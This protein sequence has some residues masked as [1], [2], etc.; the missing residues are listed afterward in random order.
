MRTRL[1]VRHVD[2]DWEAV[3]R[4]HGARFARCAVR[5]ANTLV[6]APRRRPHSYS[7]AL[8]RLAPCQVGAALVGSEYLVEVEAEAQI[9]P[10]E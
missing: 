5:P 6:C 2:R 8:S 10:R 4:V 1:Y 9:R 3:A 7:L